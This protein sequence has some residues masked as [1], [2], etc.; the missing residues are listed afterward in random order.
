[1]DLQ[2]CG[3]KAL[4][5]GATGGIGEAAARMLAA[6]GTI[7]AVNGRTGEKVNRIVAEIQAAGGQAV[8]A[9][10]DLETDAG[11]A[12]ASMA[13]RASFGSIDILVNNLGGAVHDGVRAWSEVPLDDWMA[14]YRKNVGAAVALINAFSGDMRA[15]GWGRIINVSTMAAVEPKE[16]PPEYQAAKAALNNLT[17]SLSKSLAKTGVT[18]NV[19]GSGVVL[20]ESVA[21]W[22]SDLARQRGWE[23][24]FEDHQKRY[25]SDVRP[26]AVDGLGRPEDLA[27]AIT[28]LASPRSRYITGANIRVDGGALSSI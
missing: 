4:V 23:G 12:Q 21:L 8:A 27:Y 9:L 25:A 6:E 11:L 5:T 28:M 26:L 15:A 7:V 14:S 3:K 20:T 18:A 1:M 17:K 19:V 13:V 10:G 22:I 24:T 2:L 16:T